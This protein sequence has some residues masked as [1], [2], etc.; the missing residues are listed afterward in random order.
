MSGVAAHASDDVWGV[1]SYFDA[2]ANSSLTLAEHWDGSAWSVVSTPNPAVAFAYPGFNAVTA[3]SA[4]DVWAA[5]LFTD[6]DSV[7]QTLIE[8]W[9][10]TA[11]SIVPSP[12]EGNPQAQDDLNALAAHTSSDV[13]AAGAHVYDPAN[14]YDHTLIE[15]WNGSSWAIVASPNLGNSS[16]L[17]GMSGVPGSLT[18]W[19]V[20]AYFDA[21]SQS[22]FALSMHCDGR[23]WSAIASASPPD[24]LGSA[25]NAVSALTSSDVWAAG[26][27]SIAAGASPQSG[28][29]VSRRKQNA[30]APTHAVV[31][32]SEVP[33]PTAIQRFGAARMQV[34]LTEHF[35]LLS[36]P[37]G[38]CRK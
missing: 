36:P 28:D 34:T 12:N 26:I 8:P 6:S 14:E 35:A 17:T 7:N 15:H 31:P 37:T 38:L 32:V 33:M 10:G 19:A 3:V 9:N 25:F 5:G 29:P 20:G 21:A 13:W 23:I 24:G 18:M 16:W 22:G 1:G 11:W 4:T 27:S 30:G 2:T